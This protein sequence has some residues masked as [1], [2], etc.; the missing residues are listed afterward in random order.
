MSGAGSNSGISAAPGLTVNVSGAD[1][2]TDD[3]DAWS[4]VTIAPAGFVTSAP[5]RSRSVKVRAP[6]NPAASSCATQTATTA[7]VQV[8]MTAAS[9][10]GP[11]AAAGSL[12][13]PAQ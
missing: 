6:E 11:P 8:G 7:P 2:V 13:P 3:P 5:F 9:E 1:F 10:S 12:A 4:C